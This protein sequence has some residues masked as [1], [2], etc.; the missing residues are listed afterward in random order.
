M[1]RLVQF[2]V[3]AVSIFLDRHIYMLLELIF[4]RLRF[5]LEKTFEG[6]FKLVALIPCISKQI[7]SKINDYQVCIYCIGFIPI[8][9]ICSWKGAASGSF[10]SFMFSVETII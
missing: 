9:I 10:S 4:Y 2:T 5:N 3:V 6:I 1:I 8:S 7:V